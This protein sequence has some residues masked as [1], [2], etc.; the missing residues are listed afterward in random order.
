MHP[1]ENSAL[2]IEGG[3]ASPLTTDGSESVTRR[4]QRCQSIR[5]ALGHCEERGLV[6]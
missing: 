3:L 2:R 5:P 1:A 4:P 6:R